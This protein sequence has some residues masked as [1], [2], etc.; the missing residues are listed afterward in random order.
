M[1]RSWCCCRCILARG[2]FAVAISL[3]VFGA[4]KR[5]AASSASLAKGRVASSKPSAVSTNSDDIR[6]KCSIAKATP[7]DK[8]GAAKSQPSANPACNN[9]N[10]IQLKS[11]LGLR[12]YEEGFWR[13]VVYRQIL[14]LRKHPKYDASME[15]E[16]KSL[17]H[18]TTKPG[19]SAMKQVPTS[20]KH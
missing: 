5:P 14:S 12:N 4:M 15:D 9:V 3:V 19:V 7:S 17:S 16:A 8:V 13:C 1:R 10:T 20:Q 11:S 2:V 6:Q 18:V